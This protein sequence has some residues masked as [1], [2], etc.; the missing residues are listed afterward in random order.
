MFFMRE[1]DSPKAGKHPRPCILAMVLELP[2]YHPQIQILS[3]EF[4][5]AH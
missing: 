3:V 2:A 1:K 4:Q 5:I